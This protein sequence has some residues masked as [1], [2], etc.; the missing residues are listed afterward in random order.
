M[1]EAFWASTL[2]GSF[3]VPRNPSELSEPGAESLGF[4]ETP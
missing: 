4:R 3:Q 1:P 2:G